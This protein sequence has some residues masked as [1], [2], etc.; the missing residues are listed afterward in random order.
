MKRIKCYVGVPVEFAGATMEVPEE[1]HMDRLHNP[2]F[3]TLGTVCT[4]LGAKF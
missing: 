4:A 1:V 3:V 2:Q